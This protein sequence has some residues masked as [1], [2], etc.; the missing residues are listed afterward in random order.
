MT[1]TNTTRRVTYPGDGIAS[2]FAVPFKIVLDAHVTVAV[3]DA[4]GVTTVKVLTTDYTYTG[5]G[6]N[7]G[8][9]EWVST[10]PA[11]GETV[12]IERIVPLTQL[13]DLINTGSYLPLNTENELDLLMMAIQQ[14]SEATS[15]A[16]AT[17]LTEFTLVARPLAAAAWYS[18]SIMVYDVGSPSKRQTCH[19]RDFGA[20]VTF[21]WATDSE[22]SPF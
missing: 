12:I 15:A 8:S 9:V 3:L 6:L 21:M 13:L 10:L 4:A 22:G 14:I 7:S 11:T 1:V 17:T 5:A 2:S 18:K 16:A 19:K 20:A